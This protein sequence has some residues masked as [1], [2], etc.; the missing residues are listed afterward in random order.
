MTKRAK[1]DDLA[2]LISPADW[3]DLVKLADLS[4]LPDLEEIDLPDLEEI[5]LSGLF[6]LGEIDD[7]I[8]SVDR[9][10]QAREVIESMRAAKA[11]LDALLSGVD[12]R[13]YA[14]RKA[15]VE[16]YNAE[17]GTF[18]KWLEKKRGGNDNGTGNT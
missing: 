3:D 7:L 14:R 4:D 17:T 1:K 9:D 12:M 13:P 5:D 2:D 10:G 16:P 6:D 11:D 15:A 18:V 8:N